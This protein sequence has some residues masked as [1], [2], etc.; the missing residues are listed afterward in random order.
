MSGQGNLELAAAIVGIFRHHGAGALVV[1]PGARSSALA[2]VIGPE[3]VSHFDERAAGF[4][5]LGRAK[6]S[7]RPS[8]VVTTSGTAVANL[9]PAAVEALHSEVPIIFLTADRPSW[10][11]DSGANQTIDQRAI[12]GPSVLWWGEVPEHGNRVKAARPVAN[13]AWEV[14][15]GIPQGPVHL[16]C[17]FDEPLLSGTRATDLPLNDLM[18]ARGPCA[19]QRGE[20]QWEVPEAQGQGLIVVGQLSEDEQSQ[21]E[22]IV[23]LGK[24][25]GWPIFA[26][27]LAGLRPSP[28]VIPH[29]DL[30]LASKNWPAPR[31]V[32]HLG[33]RLVSKR[34]G[35]FASQAPSHSSFHISRSPRPLDPWGQNPQHL[36]LDPILFCR[37][38]LESS[39]P[40]EAGWLRQWQEAGQEAEKFL[41]RRLQG[42]LCEPTVA[43]LVAEELPEGA[44][45]FL[46]N[47]LPVRDFDSFAIWR[48]SQRRIH[49]NRGASGIDGNIATAAGLAEH[50]P[51]VALIGDIAALHDLNSLSLARARH[52]PLTLVVVNNQGGGIFR[53]LNLPGVP[54]DP[55]WET[56]HNF[57]LATLA[58]AFGWKSSRPETCEEFVKALQQAMSLA[59]PT[60]IEIFSDK[61]GNHRLHCELI[62]E[63]AKD[64]T[65]RLLT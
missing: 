56:S 38:L 2:A 21:S 34:V 24:K 62:Q 28:M 48:G 26:D 36:V 47:S 3:G 58:A 22:V 6:A 46:G 42:K 40:A 60:L 7:G 55:L 49:G 37:Q 27:A 44:R 4:Y 29:A 23:E 50:G 32:V 57:S 13:Y 41:R 20:T 39:R 14:A 25:W 33:G 19:P 12:F 11:R 5:A 31:A 52:L 18:P 61:T 53:F 64:D 10:L 35:L 51:T 15:T 16:N 59:E 17:S 8:V 1:C 54:L 43:R 63:C 30:L 65:E 45:L 9:H